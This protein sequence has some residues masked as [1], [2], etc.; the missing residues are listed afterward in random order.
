[1]ST[2]TRDRIVDEAMRLFSD[3]GYRATTIAKIE[4]AAGLTPGAGGVYH[5]FHS[6]EAVLEAGLQ[7]QLARIESLGAVRQLFSPLGDLRAEL[8]LI[9]RYVL[10]QLDEETQLIR[11]LALSARGGP[12]GLAEAAQR[13]A[14]TSFAGFADWIAERAPHLSADRASPLAATALG[15]LLSSRLLRDVLGINPSV[16][17]AALVD[18]W[19]HMMRQLLRDDCV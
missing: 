18:N 6:K 3:H 8:T 9:A 7:R 13:L 1:M 11:L 10:A 5:H 14:D 19:V 4:A 12:A 2:T 17:D 16:D 15:S